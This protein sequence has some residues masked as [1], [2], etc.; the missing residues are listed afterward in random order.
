VCNNKAVCMSRHTP[1]NAVL[2]IA[3]AGVVV[4]VMVGGRQPV[5]AGRTRS[6]RVAQG[7]CP[8]RSH[9]VVAPQAKPR[10]E[11]PTLDQLLSAVDQARMCTTRRRVSDATI[12]RARALQ[13]TTD[14]FEGSVTPC[15]AAMF[16][17]PSA[18]RSR[19]GTLL[20]QA[21]S[22]SRGCW[23]PSR[24]C[25]HHSPQH[26]AMSSIKHVSTQAAA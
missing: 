11:T 23:K 22:R 9:Q 8:S 25:G 20:L 6:K 13:E 17:N 1:R 26:I 10:W 7:A 15:R 3:V 24:N 19:A 12:T 4:A 21:P 2:L 16:A 18:T 5:R 14:M